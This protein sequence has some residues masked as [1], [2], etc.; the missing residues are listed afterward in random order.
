MH[1]GHCGRQINNQ[2][3][4]KLSFMICLCMNYYLVKK[5]I[6]NILAL[7]LDYFSIFVYRALLSKEINIVFNWPRPSSPLKLET[8]CVV[9]YATFFVS[10]S[11]LISIYKLKER[12]DIFFNWFHVNVHVHKVKTRE[13][14]WKS[15]LQRLNRLDI[16]FCKRDNF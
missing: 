13:K 11:F 6:Q 8:A 7:K 16:T 4:V 5:K 9:L 1:L 14:K 10:I 12:C 2:N 3:F 15:V